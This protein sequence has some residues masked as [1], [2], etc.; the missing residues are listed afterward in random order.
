MFVTSATTPKWVPKNWTTI[1]GNTAGALTF[2]AIPS[3]PIASAA[4]I[5][6][7]IVPADIT[8]TKNYFYKL[9][10][11]NPSDPSYDGIARSSK[12][13]VESKYSARWERSRRTPW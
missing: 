12:D 7:G 3:A 6:W 11:W 9:P 10:S 4:K 2:T 1:T 8:V 13:F 5:L